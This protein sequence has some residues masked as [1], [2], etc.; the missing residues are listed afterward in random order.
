MSK[1]TA[2]LGRVMRRDKSV[3][4]RHVGGC[5]RVLNSRR[6][7]TRDHMISQSYIRSMPPARKREFNEDWNIQPTCRECNNAKGGQLDAWPLYRCTCHYLQIGDDGGMYIHEG[8]RKR[9][10]KHL[11]A[12]RIVGGG[13]K[14]LD[15]TLVGREFPHHP[16]EIDAGAF[17]FWRGLTGHLLPHVSKDLVMPFNW[18]EQVRVGKAA[19]PIVFTRDGKVCTFLPNGRI[20]PGSRDWCAR[21]FRRDWG[22]HNIRLNPFKPAQPGEADPTSPSQGRPD[23]HLLMRSIK[24]SETRQ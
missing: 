13:G 21:F 2:Q 24:Q 6:E 9:E 18:F 22:H 14:M 15:F 3:C 17:G 7:A 4:G 11:L 16:D 8:T 19:D 10:K 1:L 5:G 20:V 12:E 23:W